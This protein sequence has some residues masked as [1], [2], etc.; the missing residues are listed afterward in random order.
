MIALSEYSISNRGSVNRSI[1]IAKNA[2][3]DGI[4]L[5]L[6]ENGGFSYESSD[7][8]FLAVKQ[9]LNGS[10]MFISDLSVGGCPISSSDLSQREKAKAKLKRAIEAAALLGT[11]A[12]LLIPGAVTNES[13]Y[14][15]VYKS[16]VTA[17][18]EFAPVAEKN[19]VNLCVE[20]VWNGFLLSPF[21]FRNLIDDVNS[22]FVNA[23]FDVGN[24]VFSSL[25]E[26][27]IEI[28]GN[29]ICRVHFKDFRKSAAGAAGFVMIGEGDVNY[30]DVMNALKKIGYNSFYTSEADPPKPGIKGFEELFYKFTADTMRNIINEE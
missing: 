19:R 23:Y 27:W 20:N 11:D 24:V 3:F 25:P 28:L 21:D 8:E 16:C 12:V 10:G 18:K 6:R 30:C 15:D 2:G 5:A 29:R 26:Q 7:S 9:F 22:P 17:L 4:Q 13:A 1:E 14:N